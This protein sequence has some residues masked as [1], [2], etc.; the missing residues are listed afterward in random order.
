MTVRH[1]IAEPRRETGAWSPEDLMRTR[2]VRGGYEGRTRRPKARRNSG[3]A[4]AV[5]ALMDHAG[6]EAISEGFRLAQSERAVPGGA[7][8]TDYATPFSASSP[9]LLPSVRQN[10]EY[11]TMSQVQ[12]TSVA[13][14][15]LAA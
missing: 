8:A 1:E 14:A 15:R 10:C 9:S 3:S 4:I 13:S 12:K 5:E 7:G 11:G 2:V 6:Q